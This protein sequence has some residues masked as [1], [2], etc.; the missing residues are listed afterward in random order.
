LMDL[1]SDDEACRA[2]GSAGLT[3]AG[4]YGWDAVASEQ[5]RVYLEVV[6]L[7]PSETGSA[8]PGKLRV[9]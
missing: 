2:L 7:E 8:L 4:R 9:G 3:H 1:L 5:E 6:G